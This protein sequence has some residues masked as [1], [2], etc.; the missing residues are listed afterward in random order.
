MSNYRPLHTT[1]VCW[2]L[3]PS[4][5]SALVPH[6]LIHFTW[7]TV[8]PDVLTAQCA[9]GS[10]WG[11]Y[12]LED[13]FSPHWGLRILPDL[14]WDYFLLSMFHIS[15]YNTGCCSNS[16]GKRASCA[17]HLILP[18]CDH[19][20]CTLGRLNNRCWLF[21]VLKTGK[22][23]GLAEVL[24]IQNSSFWITDFCHFFLTSISSRALI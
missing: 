16:K 9:N 12:Q 1:L 3:C 18:S 22:P 17:E 20:C 11:V 14:G 7:L 8:S 6:L 13:L 2:L 21:I 15:L 19:E 24:Y 5:V 10:V 4:W 23:V